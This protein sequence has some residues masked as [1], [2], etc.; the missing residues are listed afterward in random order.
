MLEGEPGAL[1]R[2]EISDF[3]G[4]SPLQD[5]TGALEQRGD[6]GATHDIP[7]AVTNEDRAD[8]SRAW[9]LAGHTEHPEH[10]CMPYVPLFAS[11]WSRRASATPARG[12]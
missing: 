11:D 5:L 8:L 3:G 7:E 1:L 4:L 2:F 6:A 10:H 9:Q 12:H